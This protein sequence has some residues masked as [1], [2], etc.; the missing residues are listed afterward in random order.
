MKPLLMAAL[1]TIVS[2]GTTAFTQTTAGSLA[3]LQQPHATARH[4]IEPSPPELDLP[5]PPEPLYN[6]PLTGRAMQPARPA[7]RMTA[8]D[9]GS[10]A[11]STTATAAQLQALPLSGRNWESFVLDA[12]P[13]ASSAHGP[14]ESSPRGGEQPSSVTVDNA[15]I[16]LAFGGRGVGRMRS[17]GAVLIG[18]GA[19][20]AAIRAVQSVAGGADAEGDR[21]AAR[22]ANVQTERGTGALHGQ[23]FLFNRSNLWGAQNPFTQWIKQTATATLTAVPVFTPLAYTPGDHSLT[24]GA[25]AGGRILRSRLFWFAALDGYQRNHPG[26]STVKHPDHFF[27]QPSNDQMQVLSARLGLS[28]VDPVSEGLAAYSKMLGTLDGLLGP[29]PRTSAQWTGFARL[30]WQAAERHR[31]TLEG[32]GAHWDSPGGGL[33]RTSEMY[34]N[35]SYGATTATEQWLLGRWE[36]FVTPNLLAVTQ[37]SFGHQIQG[38][39]AGQPSSFEQSLNINAWGQLPQMVVDARYGFTIGNPTW[40]GR[41]SYPDEHLYEAQEQLDW[42]RGPL[43]LKAGFDMRHNTDATSLL[44]NQ[45]GKYYYSSVENFV[46]DAL[47]FAAFGINGQLN[48][49]DQHNCDETGRAWRDADGTLHG[50]GYLPCYTYYSQLMGP[51]DWWLSTN[52]W[53]GYVTAQWQP[54]KD[55]VLTAAM[56]W[57]REQ[58][59]PPLSALSNPDLPLTQRIPSPGNE[60]GPRMSLA[61]GR[62]ETRWPV[63]RLG[64]G[65]YYGR[66]P[67]ATL[68]TALTQTG[69]L[70]GDLYFFMRP[71]DNLNAGG[72]PPFPYVLAGQPGSVVMPG[73]VEFAP[74]FR[75]GEVHQAVATLE[76]DLPGRI[77]LAASAVLSLGRRLP[78]TFDANIDPAV[79]PQ[80]ITY[81]VVDGSGK[82]PIKT[83]QITVPFYASWPSPTSPT[84]LGGRLN[85]NYQQIIQVASRA[86]STYEALML[87]LARYGRHGLALRGHYTF[88]HAA[89]WNPNESAWVS[90]SS[91]LDP[92]NFRQEYGTSN[93]DVRHSA[94][95]ALVWEPTWHL[96]S[97]AGRLANGWMLSAIGYFHSGMPF[98]MRTE[99]SLPREYTASG[100]AIVGLAPGING[101]GGDNRLYGIGRN[102]WRYPAA[103]KADMRMGRHFKLGRTTQ[104]ELLAE[105]FNLLNHQNVTELETVG[106]TVRS[107]TR[108]Q[109]LPTLNFL[110][111]LKPGQTEFG[112][113]LNINATNFYRQRQLQFGL[114]L[115]F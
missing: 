7:S 45:T 88:A 74:A 110:T 97:G 17:R 54:R 91:V 20:E 6:L 42:V 98:T 51:T 21:S 65:M 8:V 53:A 68:E 64:Y 90:G 14:V 107:G 115:R 52:D 100:A 41:G 93:L 108:A 111:G 18:P 58:M 79:N 70:K 4:R 24:F 105:S 104:L 25:G 38:E 31:I 47:S 103:W 49:F 94:S 78:I 112:Q 44:R 36:A 29:A 48:P 60:W 82:G 106:Y 96:R 80:T 85:P 75:N 32:S 27:A 50:L 67:N 57:Q 55:L 33:S 34:G 3:P 43:M 1:L 56:R 81:A 102:S 66:T 30:D 13:A 37:G 114:R 23:A 89:D 19:S 87:R 109:R 69:S 10:S 77:M 61:W 12:P 22:R 83:P 15:S 76:E 101:Y 84:G 99:G 2:A 35:H 9:T 86:N 39:P 16:R 40:F 59:P 92:A 62:G 5:L 11:L 63:L 73:A 71:T 95:T 26:V 28:S 113:P 46:S 72:A